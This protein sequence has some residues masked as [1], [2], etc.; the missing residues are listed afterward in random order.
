VGWSNGPNSKRSGQSFGD[1]IGRKDGIGDQSQFKILCE[2]VSSELHIN[3]GMCPELDREWDGRKPESDSKDPKT[4]D[5][6]EYT[7][8]AFAS[9]SFLI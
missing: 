7:K 1:A 3:R 8:V 6:T 2:W 5:G 9:V 4:D